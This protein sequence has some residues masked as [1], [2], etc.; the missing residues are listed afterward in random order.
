M[1][2]SLIAFSCLYKFVFPWVNN[3]F[4]FLWV[5]KESPQCIWR[6][7]ITFSL[8]R[9]LL[10]VIVLGL[11][12]GQASR[13]VVILG[14][15]NL[16]SPLIWPFPALLP[17]AAFLDSWVTSSS[18]WFVPSFC[19]STESSGFMRKVTREVNFLRPHLSEETFI[20]PSDLI[21]GLGI[22]F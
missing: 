9:D 14:W 16:L 22:E 1:L 13:T 21:I 3:Y 20:L 8:E 10:K 17:W 7:L 4:N 6:Y 2:Y 19:W 15:V 12:S 18:F 11:P 5:S